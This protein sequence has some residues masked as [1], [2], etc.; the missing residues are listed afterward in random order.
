MRRLG[1][2][3]GIERRPQTRGVV[4]EGLGGGEDGVEEVAESDDEELVEVE[5]ER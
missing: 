5:E 2:P 3:V 1:L 4:D